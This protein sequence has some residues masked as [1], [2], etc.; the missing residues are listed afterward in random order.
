MLFTAS[1]Q[2]VTAFL[3]LQYT[4][5]EI[6]ALPDLFNYN[7]KTTQDL[8]IA[9]Y[10]YLFSSAKMLDGSLSTPIMRSP[11]F[12][13]KLKMNY[14]TKKDEQDINHVSLQG[15]CVDVRILCLDSICY[16][17]VLLLIITSQATIIWNL[18]AF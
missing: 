4:V 11:A 8:I 17:D 15:F 12:N 3:L 16:G 10:M 2:P 13:M 9:N 14:I 18:L 6:L 1:A 5:R 7:F